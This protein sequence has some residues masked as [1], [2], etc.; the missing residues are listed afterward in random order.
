[1]PR[2]RRLR[3]YRYFR[4]F[5]VIFV[6]YNT[7]EA[8][9]V[10][11]AQ[12]H[13][14]PVNPPQNIRVYIASIHWNNEPILRDYWNKAVVDLVKVLGPENV[15]VSVYESGS[16]D[17]S[18][19]ALRSLD[20]TLGDLGVR[21]N[22]TLSDTTHLDEISQSPVGSGWID[23]SRGRKELRRI[24]YLSRLRN[25]TLW[26]L[27]QLFQQGIVFDKVLFLND[28]IFTVGCSIHGPFLL[29][30]SYSRQMIFSPF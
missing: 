8:L 3:I 6:L 19:G 27:G 2:F 17:D 29:A 1:M 26:N 7:L 5:L 28:V 10:R 15:F 23:T 9:Y 24:P 20:R 21:R 30:Y 16:W 14:P 13:S 25:Y 11:T 18:K 12:L 22:I 4:P